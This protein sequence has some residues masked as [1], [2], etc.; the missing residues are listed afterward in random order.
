MVAIKKVPVSSR[1][2]EEEAEESKQKIRIKIRAYDHKIID[3]ST[4]TIM[5]TA[6]RTGAKVLGPIP[7][8]TEKKK[9]TVIRSS[10]VH[11]DSRDQYEMRIHK[12]LLDIIDPTPK[13]VDSLTNLNLPA[14]VD[15][16]IKMV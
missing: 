5:E 7:L 13:T 1:K 15:V 6:E 16:E 14:G 8:P 11:K 12:R 10:F 3:Q 4:R 9:Y 2:A